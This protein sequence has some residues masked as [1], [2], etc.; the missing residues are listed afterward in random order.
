MKPS[1]SRRAAWTLAA[2]AGVAAAPSLAA[3]DQVVAIT[4]DGHLITFD[5][6]TPGTLT[7][8]VVLTGIPGNIVAIDI[9]PADG[10]LY[11]VTGGAR[12]YRVDASTGVAVAVGANPFTTSLGALTGMDFAAGSNQIRIVNDLN[13]NLR[14]SA[15]DGSLVDGDTLLPGVQEDRQLAYGLSDLNAGTDPTVVAITS[16]DGAV[17]GIDANL[18]ILVTINPP[19]DGT[20]HTVG[21]LGVNVSSVAGFDASPTTP[22]AFAVLTLSGQGVSGAYNANLTT[23]GVTFNGNVGYPGTIVAMAVGPTT[24]ITPVEN[25]NLVGLTQGAELIRFESDDP[26]TIKSRVAITGLISGDTLIAVDERPSNRRLYGLG[27]GGRIYAI[28]SLTGLASPIRAAPFEV[29]LNGAVF[30]FDFNPATNRIRI[31]S[32]QGQNLRVDPDTGAVLDGNVPTAGTQAD[33]SLA[34]ASGDVNQDATPHVVAAAHAGSGSGANPSTLYVIDS[35]LDILARQGA[36]GG[37]SESPNTGRLH[38]VG[39]LGVDATNVTSFEIVDNS[40][41]FASFAAADGSARLFSIDLASGL[42]SF[43]DNIGVGETLRDLASAPGAN[44]PAPGADLTIENLVIRFDYARP[45]RD[46]VVIDGVLPLPTGSVEGQVVMVDV[47][48]YSKAFILDSRSNAKDDGT[49]RSRKDDDK[50]AFSDRPRDGHVQ[51]TVRLRREDLSDELTDEGMGGTENATKAGRTVQIT[52][53]VNG[54]MYTVSVP[55]RFTAKAGRTGVATNVR[56]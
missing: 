9:R 37:Q 23:G 31:V 52:I 10:V 1:R 55:L 44:P 27:S 51:F 41:A 25:S 13:R 12:L 43:I 30:S 18:D 15:N 38:T 45:D 22:S 46:S 8:D 36:V 3:A 5:S 7:R 26:A 20:L 29:P 48:G 4:S 34:Y 32:D 28:N 2:L 21:A 50:F 39:S 47:G 17:Y 24:G 33:P 53:T 56:N 42:A 11:A 35:N 6:A 19:R 40:T 49:T 16:D 54:D 14:V